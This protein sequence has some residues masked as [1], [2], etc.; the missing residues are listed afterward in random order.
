MEVKT[1]A[2]AK[3]NVGLEVEGATVHDVLVLIHRGHQR[4]PYRRYDVAMVPPHGG[5]PKWLCEGGLTV[6]PEG[7]C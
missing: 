2:E 1:E 3:P 4:G 5:W 7:W 6:G